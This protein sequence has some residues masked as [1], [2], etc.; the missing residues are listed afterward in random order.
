MSK[1]WI[2]LAAAIVV[3]PCADTQAD[4]REVNV[5]LTS[6][7]QVTAAELLAVRSNALLIAREPGL[8]E[9]QLKKDTLAVE[10][11]PLDQVEHVT[12]KKNSHVLSGVLI[13]LPLGMVVGGIIGASSGEEPKNEGEAIVKEL[14]AQPAS[15]AVGIGVG[16]LGG[17]LVGALVGS[18]ASQGEQAVQPADSSKLQKFCRYQD[19][20]PEYLQRVR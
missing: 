20:E 12:I 16:A 2:I 5:Y 13:G 9:R 7:G 6:G 19:E 18:A 17:L 11:I 10:L 14:V 3:I 4:G 15:I 8:S 1:M